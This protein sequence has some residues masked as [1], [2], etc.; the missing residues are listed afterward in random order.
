[1]LP[2]PT[3]D[4]HYR[5]TLIAYGDGLGPPW[6]VP[7]FRLADHLWV[8]RPWLWPPARIDLCDIIASGRL[9]ALTA[10]CKM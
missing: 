6:A 3:S 5:S 8:P 1:M 4:T 9:R 2:T 10:Y 7:G